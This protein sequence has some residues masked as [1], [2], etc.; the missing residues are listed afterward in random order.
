M[1]N[2]HA[3]LTILFIRNVNNKNSDDMFSIRPSK[4]SNNMYSVIYRDRESHIRNDN[5]CS[6]DEVLDFV[7]SIFDLLP[8]D[9]DPFLNVQINAPT[10]P[11]VMMAVKRL[12]SYT[13]R[14]S[15][16][17]I[18]KNTMRNWPVAVNDEITVRRPTTRSTVRG[19]SARNPA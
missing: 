12:E 5:I 9:E 15:I 10:F 19:L 13:V 1:N 2:T 11:C 6:E 8:I 16:C 18:V 4:V 3:A 17:S 14:D 7:H